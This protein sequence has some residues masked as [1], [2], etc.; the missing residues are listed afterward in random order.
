MEQEP[1]QDFVQLRPSDIMKNNRREFGG[2]MDAKVQAVPSVAFSLF[3][4]ERIA[5][6][7]APR[8]VRAVDVEGSCAA[9]LRVPQDSSLVDPEN[10]QDENEQGR[11]QTEGREKYRV[12]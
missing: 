6:S 2:V 9:R 3:S 11:I 8:S 10:E 1:H 4:L 7:S 5:D 12:T